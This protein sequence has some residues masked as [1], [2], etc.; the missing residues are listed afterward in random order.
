MSNNKDL[1]SSNVAVFLG[2]SR[3]M[4]KSLI[5]RTGKSILGSVDLESC[6]SQLNASDI[7][8]GLTTIQVI[9]KSFAL[10]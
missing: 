6:Y 2:W 1:F 10:A 4:M 5:Q 7:L 3:I 9:N 8:K